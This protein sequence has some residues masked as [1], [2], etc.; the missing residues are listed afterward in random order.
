VNAANTPLSS[1]PGAGWQILAE[2]VLPVEVSTGDAIHEWLADSLQPLNLPADFM[3][4]IL[5][6]AL[7][8]ATRSMQADAL[9]KPDHTHII[10][11][12]MQQYAENGKSW[13]FFQVDKIEGPKELHHLSDHTVEYYLYVEGE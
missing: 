4:K 12:V 13:G 5:R 6:S 3:D 8:I 10:I 7:D 1:M 11:L 9:E 2:L